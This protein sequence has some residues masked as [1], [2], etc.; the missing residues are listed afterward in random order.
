MLLLLSLC[1]RTESCVCH[2]V[3]RT[4]EHL[5]HRYSTSSCRVAA[6]PDSDAPT[7][8]AWYSGSDSSG[9]LPSGGFPTGTM[10]KAGRL[11]Y[12]T[13]KRSPCLTFSTTSWSCFQS[14]STALNVSNAMVAT[15]LLLLHL[16]QGVKHALDECNEYAT[17]SPCSKSA[18]TPTTIGCTNS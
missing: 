17:V 7:A 14:A 11:R 10:S 4:H 1:Q 13:E 18:I 16:A 3:R 12:K 6:S 5:S 2:T 8:G 9:I 15:N